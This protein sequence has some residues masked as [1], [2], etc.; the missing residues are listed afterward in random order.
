MG[1]VLSP[2]ISNI[3]LSAL[4][5]HF[6]QAWQAMGGRPGREAIRRR[7]GATYRLIRYADLC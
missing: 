2:L 1:A 3:A 6:A 7:G 4:D 5:E